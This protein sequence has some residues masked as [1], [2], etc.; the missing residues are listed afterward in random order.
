VTAL[1][2]NKRAIND[3]KRALRIF[4]TGIEDVDK[5]TG[6]FVN[7]LKLLA[8]WYV[9]GKV[10]NYANSIRKSLTSAYEAGAK[11][12]TM[13][14]RTTEAENAAVVA[15]SEEAGVAVDAAF[16][17]IAIAQ[18]AVIATIEIVSTGRPSNAGSAT[19]GG[20]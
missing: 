1:E 16:P 10:L 12:V 13:F 5:V 3:G 17:W 2:H 14:R 7:T 15:S 9:T 18:L 6:S 11:A 8:A 19:S 20:T 4:E